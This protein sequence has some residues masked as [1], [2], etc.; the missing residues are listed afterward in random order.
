MIPLA[1]WLDPKLS[2]PPPHPPLRPML[3]STVVVPRASLFAARHVQP[4]VRQA[5]SSAGSRIMVESAWGAV[6]GLL[7][8]RFPRPLAEPAVPV[9]RQRALHGICRRAWLCVPGAGDLA[10]AVAIPGNRHLGDVEQLDPVRR[11]PEPPAVGAGEVPAD[12][13]PSPA[14]QV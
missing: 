2:S 9:S 6:P 11:R 8:V 12:V 4:A 10:A 13:L 1:T 14:A 3:A 7:P 5:R